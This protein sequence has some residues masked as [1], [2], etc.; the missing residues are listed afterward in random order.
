MPRNMRLAVM[1]HLDLVQTLP[2]CGPPTKITAFNMIVD[3]L[4]YETTFL[5]IQ[6]PLFKTLINS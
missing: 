6:I 1:N 5:T 4:R 3:L 2:F